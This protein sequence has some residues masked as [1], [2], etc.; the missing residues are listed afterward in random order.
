[1]LRMIKTA[2]LSAALLLAVTAS[3]DAQAMG[4]CLPHGQAVTKLGQQYGEHQVGIGIG[5]KG[6]SVIELFVAES[7]TW[8]I[9][10]TQTNGM[11]C[12]T[13]S[14]D[15]WSASPLRVGDAT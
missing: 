15:N 14:G 3:A 12:I 1:M 7:G 9:L 11:S 4:P 6:S 5:S 13:A 8:T 2:L 10:M